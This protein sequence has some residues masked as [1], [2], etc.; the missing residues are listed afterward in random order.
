MKKVIFAFFIFL[1]PIYV[2]AYSKNVILGG[3]SIG[4]KIQSDGLVVVGYYKVDNDYINKNILI[5]DRIV[6]IDNIRISSI[7]EMINVLNE[8]KDYFDIDLIRNNKTIKEKLILKEYNNSFKTGLYVK[9]NIMGIGT[10][11]YIDPISKIYGSLGHEILFS[12]TNSRVIIKNGNI[13]ESLITS[14]SKS[15]N[16]FVGTKKANIFFDKEIGNIKL[17]TS[18]GIYGFYN[19]KT[20]KT[21]IEVASYEEIKKGKAYILTVSDN[22]KINKYE[23]NI[24]EKYDKNSSKAFGF[25]VTDK[26]LINSFGGI[27]QGMSGSPIIQN[28]KLIGAVTNVVVD[29]VTLG[30]GISIITMLEEGDKL[31]N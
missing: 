10:I 24:I 3:E 5:G 9:D 8:D 29:D 30:Y 16:G 15:R 31:R 18:N 17:N 12:D 22:K 20:N 4:I 7:N 11:T 28:N 14:I 1:F 21:T 23:I 25:K 13:Y 27:V 2:F 6:K 26:N 19:K